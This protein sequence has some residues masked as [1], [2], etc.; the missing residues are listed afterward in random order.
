MAVKKYVFSIILSVLSLAAIGFVLANL[1]NKP[2]M[3]TDADNSRLLLFIVASAMFILALVFIIA[4]IL[5]HYKRNFGK[6][7]LEEEYE[8]ALLEE[9]QKEEEQDQ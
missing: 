5:R 6:D 2:R 8:R 4:F 1:F 7:D 3:R 9:L